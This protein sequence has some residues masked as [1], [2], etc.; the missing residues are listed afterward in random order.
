MI[1]MVLAGGLAAI[2]WLAMVGTKLDVG[3][4]I[5]LA[6]WYG[7]LGGVVGL[8]VG[9]VAGMAVLS[10]IL[11]YHGD[12]ASETTGTSSTHEFKRVLTYDR[13]RLKGAGLLLIVT[14]FLGFCAW[15]GVGLFW[16]PDI[17]RHRGDG[18]FQNISRRAGW[19]VVGYTI[20]MPEFDL[21]SPRQSEYRVAELPQ[22]GRCGL[23]LAIRDPEDTWWRSEDE[24]QVSGRLELVMTDSS[25][26]TVVK[27]EGKARRFHL[28][29]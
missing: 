9:A 7:I 12:P 15:C 14:L 24:R 17:P 4:T 27:T 13:A 10:V 23:Y 5:W 3:D 1:G 18:V 2:P 19:V 29:R 16:I 25:G 20:S 28:V 22:R 21:S 6:I 8:I 26:K 11:L